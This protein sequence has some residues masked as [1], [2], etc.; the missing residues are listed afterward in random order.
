MAARGS[1]CTGVEVRSGAAAGAE[2]RRSPAAQ[3]SRA[4][5]RRST[6]ARS[7]AC[8]AACACPT[9]PTYRETGR[10]TSSPR[11]RIY[12][13]RGVAEGR[14]PLG[15]VGAPRRRISVSA[16][17]LARRPAR[18][19]SATARCSSGTRHEVQRAGLRRGPVARHR[20]PRAAPRRPAAARAARRGRAARARCSACG[21]DALAAR[22]LPARAAR[23][24]RAAAAACR[25]RS[26]ARAAARARAARRARAAG[27]SRFFARLR[28]VGALRRR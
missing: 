7:T 8:T 10:E 9:C 13:M 16:A 12:L 22:L 21:L 17:A 27:A 23:R 11:G 15:D 24:A 5:G 26:S 1:A 2:L 3:R 4:A 20:A 25:P 19:A 28:D 18:P 14:I 6:R